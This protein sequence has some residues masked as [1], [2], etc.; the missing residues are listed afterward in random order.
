M[1][2]LAGALSPTLT[3]ATQVA[4]DY[5]GAQ[6]K[7][8][9]LKQ[10]MMIAAMTMR[11]EQQ[12]ADIKQAVANSVIPKN[13]AE[14][15]V[16]T[17]KAREPVLGDPGYAGAMGD[18]AQAQ[19]QAKLPAD[20]QLAVANHTLSMKEAVTVQ[21]M[22]S[23]TEQGIATQRVGSEATQG[24]ANRA[25]T[26]ANTGATIAGGMARV[27]QA[28]AQTL[29]GRILGVPGAPTPATTATPDPFADLVPKT[30]PPPNP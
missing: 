17:N 9:Q 24:A 27:R 15:A 4:G 1:T 3:A 8:A 20:L 18:V 13:T 11:R 19:S 16:A 22:R 7:A 5:Q 14:A 29:T 23:Q 28:G 2:F 12:L 10:Q 21:S 6:V 30:V 25:A 26:A